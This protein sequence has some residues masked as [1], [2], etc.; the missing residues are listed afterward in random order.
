[1][2]SFG[3]WIATAN[4][5]EVRVPGASK[6]IVVE[7]LTGHVTVE[8]PA[9]EPRKLEPNW[10]DTCRSAAG[11]GHQAMVLAA[12]TQLQDSGARASLNAAL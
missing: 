8:V 4:E 2:S 12:L 11:H 10:I 5:I 1:M 7:R 3:R 6:R 9:S